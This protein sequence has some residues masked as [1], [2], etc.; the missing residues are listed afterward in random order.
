MREIT[1]AQAIREAMSQAMRDDPTVFLMG[2]DVGVYG[3]A[4][5]VTLG[6]VE[7]FGA[8]RVRDTPISESVI[9]GAGAGAAGGADREVFLD[10]QRGYQ[11]VQGSAVNADAGGEVLEAH[12]VA[13]TETLVAD[14]LLE[15]LERRAASGRFGG[16]N[17]I[18]H[19]A[20]GDS[21]VLRSDINWM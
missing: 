9:V 7:E 13:A 6:M 3:G 16:Q 4:F 5:G 17:A 14:D 8:E 20:S 12:C 11:I 2:E 19:A 1:Y 15:E 21:V 18:A 10:H